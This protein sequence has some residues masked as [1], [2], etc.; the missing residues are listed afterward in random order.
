LRRFRIAHKIKSNGFEFNQYLRKRMSFRSVAKSMSETQVSSL[1]SPK[2]ISTQA[3][4]LFMNKFGLIAVAAIL[5]LAAW[6]GQTFLVVLLGL[7]LAT[8]GVAKLLSQFSLW[9]VSSERWLSG[10]RAFP[11]E[12]LEMKIRISNRKLLP[13][14]WLQFED[15]IP[16]DFASGFNIKAGDKPGFGKVSESSSISWYSARRWKYRLLCRK[17]GYYP[18]G[19]MIITTGDVFGFYRRSMLEPEIDHIIV[20]PRIYSLA[21]LNLPSLY[22]IGE[23]RADKRIFE[24]PS[25]TIGI[26]DYRPEDSLRR[27]HWKASARRHELQVKVFEPTSSVKAGLVLVGDS[28]MS[29]GNFA[30][31][32]FEEGISAAASLAS[33]LIE[34]NSQVGLWA[35]SKAADSN[36]AIKIQPRGDTNQLVEILESLAKVTTAVSSPFGEYFQ[37]ERQAFPMGMTVI[38]IFSRLT[39]DLK[40]IMTDMKANGYRNL[41]F[42]VGRADKGETVEDIPWRHI[43]TGLILEDNGGGFV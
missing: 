13:L 5:A 37:R 3:A 39:E 34:R 35:N 8:A 22:P 42:Q 40:G 32:D 10:R 30:E 24:D 7:I 20:Y 25:R 28:F 29:D 9:G 26:R 27:I 17:R 2:K 14:P 11:K 33:Y 18:L 21:F 43:P 38:F 15:Q 4:G 31:G 19:P 36:Q 12:T 16:A 6:A 1:N 23:A 41:A